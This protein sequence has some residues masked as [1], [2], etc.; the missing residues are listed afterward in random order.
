[1][2]R[3]AIFLMCDGFFRLHQLAKKQ[4]WIDSLI[5]ASFEAGE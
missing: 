1:L 5:S 2:R 4:D 3:E